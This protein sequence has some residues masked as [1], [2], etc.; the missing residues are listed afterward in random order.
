MNTS[1]NYKDPLGALKIMQLQEHLRSC[2]VDWFHQPT[3]DKAARDDA[4]KLITELEAF[5]KAHCF[6]R[7]KA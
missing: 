4:I 5:S 1:D 3:G 2:F 6:P 7:R